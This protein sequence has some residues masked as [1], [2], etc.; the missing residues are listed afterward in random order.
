[1]LAPLLASQ[2]ISAYDRPHKHDKLVVR[3]SAQGAEGCGFDPRLHH[4]KDIKSG[5][6]VL[7]GLVLDINEL[8][9]AGSASV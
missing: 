1:M 2:L 7:L 4:T 8:D 6:L 3:M 9:L 5:R